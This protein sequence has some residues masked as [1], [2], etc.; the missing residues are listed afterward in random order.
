MVT[1]D[2]VR[3]YPVGVEANREG[4]HFRVWAPI[5]SRIEVVVEG[6]PVVELA[7]EP[8]GYFSGFAEG[9]HDG[10]RYRFRL[11]GSPA[12]YPDPASRFQPDGPHGPSQVIDPSAFIWSDSAWT[13]L[14]PE[15]QVLYEMHVGTF[16]PEG[17]WSAAAARLPDL[18]ALGIT[19]V[20]LMPIADFP[21]AFGWGY[22]GVCLYAPTR[23]YGTPDD[24]RRFVDEAHTHGI[25]V[26]LDV[27][28]NHFGPDGNYVREFAPQFFSTRH[29]TQ[30]G[31]SFD[32]EGP[33][34]VP[35]REFFIANAGY[36]IDEFHLD[37]L[38]L[39]ATHAIVD[40]SPE[41][42]LAAITCR[43][44]EAARGRS[45]FLVGENELQDTKLLRDVEAGGCGLNGMWNDDLHHAV[46]VA[47][48]G[49]SEGYY[50]DFR[51]RPQ[52]LISA[53]KWG[54]LF[55]GQHYRWHKRRRGRP[56]FDIPRQRFVAYIENHDQI[57]NSARGKRLHQLTSPSSLRAATAYLLLIPSTPMLFQGQ[58]YAST[59][60]FLYFAD[61]HPDL[62]ATVY[63]AR[64][65]GTRKFRSQ[66]GADALR[67]IP[68]PADP[69]TFDRCK[70]DPAERSFRSEWVTLHRDLIALR[71][72]DPAFRVTTAF[73]GA[74]LGE[75][76]FVLRFFVPESGDRLLVVNLGGDLHLDP[77]PEPLLAPP[78]VGMHWHPVWSSEDPKY[79]GQGTAPLD[80]D[81]NWLIPGEAA[82]VLSAR[83]LH[84]PGGSGVI[85]HPG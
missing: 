21:G 40:E 35:V 64:R 25:G 29:S 55:Q 31:E 59:R 9:I 75:A 79:G 10:A 18:A 45:V 77:A 37:G 47:L 49:R 48:T 68:D 83:P 85:P 63:Q 62:A 36:W 16:T 34:S 19:A 72:S 76:A 4:S 3:R 26:I 12:L 5:R 32:F 58:E 84:R 60:P 15:G 1:T 67:L 38:R 61:H 14:A 43:A 39:D 65:D 69:S 71:R 17:T 28:Y 20:T 74:V 50:M 70:L 24:M 13:G 41:H 54:F 30:W 42:I 23:L 73:D 81:E 6:G 2:Y 46:R 53:A 78:A 57:A 80:T 44:R 22:D 51:G 66:A 33:D 82:V 11:D 52:E 27:V 8:G 56:A 7:A